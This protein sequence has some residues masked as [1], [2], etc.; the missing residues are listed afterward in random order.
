MDNCETCAFP[1]AVKMAKNLAFSF[2]NVV[3]QAFQTG[4]VMASKAT[5]ESRMARCNDCPFKKD[6]RCA[7]CGC[8]LT[9]KVGLLAES[10]PEGNW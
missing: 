2:V 9:L 5:I 8:V 4:K 7:K 3:G 1:S 10:C 6:N